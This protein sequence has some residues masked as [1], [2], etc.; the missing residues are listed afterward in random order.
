[1][2][3]L[4]K[5]MRPLGGGGKSSLLIAVMMIV[6]FAYG[7]DLTV[8]RDETISLSSD[9]VYDTITVHGTL[10][11]SNGAKVQVTTVNLG[12]DAGDQV[13][14][15]VD[16]DD[17]VFGAAK[18]TQITIGANGGTG[19]LV[20]PD[21]GNEHF[22]HWND[23]HTFGFKTLTV[24]ANAAVGED[25]YIDII[26]LK[27]SPTSGGR[28]NNEHS[29]GIA[30]V[31][32]TGNCSIGGVQ[33]WDGTFFS[34]KVELVQSNPGKTLWLTPW[35]APMTLAPAS[36]GLAFRNVDCIRVSGP[37]DAND[38]GK[39][40]FNAGVNWAGKCAIV[41]DGNTTGI[42]LGADDVLP[43]GI[44]HDSMYIYSRGWLIMNGYTQH[45]N[46]L[47]AING[48]LAAD[49]YAVTGS[50]GAK[51]IFGAGNVDGSVSGA[52]SPVVEVEKVGS[53]ELVVSNAVSMG[54]MC[55][56]EG[57]MRIKAPA[58]IKKL[59]VAEGA[60]LIV[61]GVTVTSETSGGN[62][63]VEYLNGG[64][65]KSIVTAETNM[66]KQDLSA[67]SARILCKTGKGT[68]IV[69]NPKMMASSIKVEE[70]TLAFT[71]RGYAIPLY[72]FSCTKTTDPNFNIYRFALVDVDGARSCTNLKAKAA[73]SDVS[74]L[75]PGEA[76]VPEGYAYKEYYWTVAEI[77]NSN[78][79]DGYNGSMT[80]AS[81]KL[82][83]EGVDEMN[84]TFAPPSDEKPAVAYNW[85]PA[86]S[87]HPV[88]WRFL[89]SFDNGANW[90]VVDEQNNYKNYYLTEKVWQNGTVSATDVPPAF[91]IY[92]PDV[93]AS[94]P[95]ESGMPAV[96]QVEVDAGARADFGMVTGG[97]PVNELTVDLAGAGSVTN[98]AFAADGKVMVT[99]AAEKLPRN[100]ILPLVVEGTIG[101]T[102]LS[103]WEVWYNGA[104]TSSRVKLVDGKLR[105]MARGMW[106]IFR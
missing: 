61:D 21:N 95:V 98:I 47:E 93:R 53:G 73:G 11:V 16:G 100:E 13:V 35:Y 86:W 5:T 105:L 33:Y 32:M 30:R 4:N 24:S 60:K 2:N 25:G 50:A 57:I 14:I 46:G 83:D 79:G 87:G 102:N 9:C 76:T 65:L 56:S 15:A 81:P 44:D 36:T 26:D 10:N 42:K 94:T 48:R 90:T 99:G 64:Q 67:L 80:I 71:G 84:F 58:E 75:E 22:G 8:G 72:R 38:Q 63:E 54:T 1:M 69:E 62:C 103:N 39:V 18:T 7:E 55:V 85:S 27:K 45:L 31:T 91:T 6:G 78:L 3:T 29:T 52:I 101:K 49:G 34:G 88:D 17:T 40:T 70:G 97:Q 96:M 19:K 20:A 92:C 23:R 68:V 37:G 41:I 74:T 106:I 66:R 51:L 89:A 104:K 77:F 12:P 82:A 28:I 59:I 43:Y